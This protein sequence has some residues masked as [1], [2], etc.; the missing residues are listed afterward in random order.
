MLSRVAQ[1]DAPIGNS[2]SMATSTEKAL[3]MSFAVRIFLA[4]TAGIDE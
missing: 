1:G 3:I 2:K 4:N